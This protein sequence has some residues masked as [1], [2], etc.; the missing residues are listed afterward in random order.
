MQVDPIK[1]KLK[2][3]GTKRLKPNCDILLSTS[4]FKFNMRR[5][6]LVSASSLVYSYVIA[7][8]ATSLVG[9]CR[10]SLSNPL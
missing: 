10:L 2:T 4:A 6:S 3:P 5:Y 9:Q 1:S 7:G 8:G